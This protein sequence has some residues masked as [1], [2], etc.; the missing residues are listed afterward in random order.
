MSAEA[1]GPV[2]ELLDAAGR[3]D[4]RARERLW[5]AVYDEL[6]RIARN[7]MRGEAAGRTLQATVLVN[8]AYLRLVGSGNGKW[9]NRR[10]FFAAAAKAM[11]RI[12][13]DD[14]RRRGRLKRDASRRE[15]LVEDPPDDTGQD[16]AEMLAVDEALAELEAIDPRWGE[17]VNL[18]YF[19][20][21]SIDQTAEVLG[22]SPRKVDKDWRFA[23]DW[24]HRELA[25][26]DTSIE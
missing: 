17:L 24:L 25:K 18:R 9:A 15:A 11:R 8:E 20:G 10:H 7:Q 19:V 14:A 22:V 23:R 3:G 5:H 16:L 13:V 2:T 6:H 4:E 1:Q 21:L 26:G 12:R